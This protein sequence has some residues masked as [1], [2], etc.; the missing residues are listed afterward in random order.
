MYSD[1]IFCIKYIMQAFHKR[2]TKSKVSKIAFHFPKN[3]KLVYL[4]VQQQYLSETDN[5]HRQT[6]HQQLL[7]IIFTSRKIWES[8]NA[9]ARAQ[10]GGGA[11]WAQTEEWLFKLFCEV[12]YRFSLIS[13][14]L[15]IAKTLT[16]PTFLPFGLA[17]DDQLSQR[18]YPASVASLPPNMQSYVAA[19]HIHKV[20]IFLSTAN[21]QLNIG[22]HTPKFSKHIIW[23]NSTE[24]PS[25]K[26]G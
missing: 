23:Y 24:I 22:G 17:C 12:W 15:S 21:C 9:T 26:G 13:G 5:K 16:S 4:A 3:Q 25:E 10:F 14:E 2:M 18:M 7:Q 6:F 8:W 19:H 11:D 1:V 20:F